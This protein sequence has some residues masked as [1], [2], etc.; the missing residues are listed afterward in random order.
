MIEKNKLSI[1]MQSNTC[2][3]K[4]KIMICIGKKAPDFACKAVVD[5]AEKTISLHDFPNQYKLIFFY[6]KDFTFVCPTELHALQEHMNEFKKRGVALLA[7]STDNLDTHCKWLETPKE[8][9]GIQGIT[10]PL[11]AD[12]NK[13]ISREYGVLDEKE[14][15]A[16]RG[17]F[18]VDKDNI[19]QAATIYNRNVGRSMTEMLRMIDA[20]QYTEQNGDL[21]P[22]DWQ[23]GEQGIKAD[24]KSVSDY[25]KNNHHKK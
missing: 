4:E 22:A 16:L 14:G 3:Q 11:L 5:G 1:L 15:I 24:K 17:F 25:L 21:C 19:V 13:D 20:F 10:F 6:P 2:Y 7:V 12:V 18:L 23:S 9:G 8:Q